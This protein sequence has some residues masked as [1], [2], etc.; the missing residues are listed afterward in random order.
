[1]GFSSSAPEK[2]TSID[3]VKT[4]VEEKKVDPNEII[5]VIVAAIALCSGKERVASIRIIHPS[6]NWIAYARVGASLRR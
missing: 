4:V 6:V 1:M 2:S 3:S 5:A